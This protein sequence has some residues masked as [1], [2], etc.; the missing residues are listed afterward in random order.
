[1]KKAVYPGS[2]DP[3]TNGHLDIIKRAAQVFDQV[4]VVVMI[5]PEKQGLF[6]IEERVQM[7]DNAIGDLQNVE[8]E[9]SGGLLINYMK[10]KEINVIVKG[11]RGVSDFDYEI[12]MAHMNNKLDPS[13]ETVFMMTSAQYSYISSSAV[14]QVAK[15]GGSLQGLVPDEVAK[16][17]V[18]RM[19]SI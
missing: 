17:L 7:I 3:I 10:E 2:F 15:F 5:N 14:K 9:C 18:S 4:K 16:K 11:L 8:I 13:I 19:G 1:M 6:N 12:Q